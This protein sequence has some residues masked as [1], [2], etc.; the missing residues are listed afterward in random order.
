M[1]IVTAQ[2]REE[3]FEKWNNKEKVTVSDFQSA[4]QRAEQCYVECCKAEIRKKKKL[5][6]RKYRLNTDV[7]ERERRYTYELLI[8]KRNPPCA[9]KTRKFYFAIKNKYGSVQ[10]YN[11][12]KRLEGK[13][14][15]EK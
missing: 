14:K 3:L 13:V 12:I 5:Y 7:R 8:G 1:K 11:D 2:K 10:A 6:Q 15:K 4:V 9:E